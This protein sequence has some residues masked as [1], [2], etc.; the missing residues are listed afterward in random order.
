[1]PN[2]YPFILRELPF[3]PGA[4]EPYIDEQTV[5]I[6][7]T[8]HQQ[9]YV[10]TLNSILEPY[11]QFHTWSLEKLLRDYCLLPSKIQT[12]V[13]N[14]AGGVYNHDLYFHFLGGAGTKPN[15]M[16]FQAIKSQ[17]GSVENMAKQLKEAA[18]SQF[19]SGYAWLCSNTSGR[20]QIEK[21]ANQDTI[22]NLGLYP[23]LVV[24]VW[25]HAYYLKYKNRRDEYFD[26]WF[27]VIDWTK[28]QEAYKISLSFYAK[29]KTKKR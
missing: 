2:H 6:H 8:K 11:S 29:S 22:I 15:G 12:D 25:E 18:L 13:R 28:A 19:G 20:L 17:F 4:L 14:N 5:I 23:V 16:L 1:M 9:K 27:E 24:D 21:T 10:D 7:H 26:G 3:S